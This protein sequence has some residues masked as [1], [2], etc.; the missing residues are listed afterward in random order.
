MRAEMYTG[1]VL[2]VIGWII[3]MILIVKSVVRVPEDHAYVVRS[4]AGGHRVLEPGMHIVVPLLSRVAAKLSTLEQVVDVRERLC[5]LGDGTRAAVRGTVTF[6]VADAAR[7]VSQVRDFRTGITDLAGSE[8]VRALGES[9]EA[10]A[11]AAVQGA[12]PTIRSSAAAWG[13]DVLAAGPLLMMG[14]DLA[15]PAP[16]LEAELAPPKP[17]AAAPVSEETQKTPAEPERP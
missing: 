2:I 3:V 9:N 1:I 5:T 14:E 7:A 11:L 10:G 8:W 13:L 12:E 17:E 6:K 4:L 15:P 16:T